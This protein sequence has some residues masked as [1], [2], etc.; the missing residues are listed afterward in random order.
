MEEFCIQTFLGFYKAGC[1]TDPRGIVLGEGS[2][3]IVLEEMDSALARK[4]KIYAEVLGFGSAVQDLKKSMQLSLEETGFVPEKI[5]YINAAANSTEEF[6]AGEAE[7]IAGLFRDK[8]K[9]IPVSSIKPLIGESFSASGS[10]QVAA[11]ISAIE[12]QMVP[13]KIINNAQVSKIENVLINA[14]GKS[15]TN[16]SLIISKFKRY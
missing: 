15:G 10:L 14:A 2:G 9:T 5:D 13:A 12:S 6:H 7:A 1:L 3:I 16:S 11:G 4:A 8:T